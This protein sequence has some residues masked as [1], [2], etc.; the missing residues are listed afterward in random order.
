MYP[1]KTQTAALPKRRKA[2]RHLT[3]DARQTV[4]ASA[5]H[6]CIDKHASSV[7]N[8]QPNGSAGEACGGHAWKYE[9]PGD[10]SVVMVPVPY[11]PSMSVICPVTFALRSVLIYLYIS[12]PFAFLLLLGGEASEGS[13]AFPGCAWCFG[14]SDGGGSGG[15]EG[16][17]A[18]VVKRAGGAVPSGSSLDGC[19]S[20]C[21]ME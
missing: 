5:Q 1:K 7:R 4:R 21:C 8:S 13:A 2:A 9:V 11:K 16:V 12:W 20:L 10:L 18:V 19:M 15:E 14:A 17:E 6:T 3:E